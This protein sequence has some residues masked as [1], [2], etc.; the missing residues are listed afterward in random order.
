MLS[1]GNKRKDIF[2]DDRDRLTR[3][4]DQASKLHQV[5]TEY[6]IRCKPVRSTW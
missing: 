3:I 1:R 5:H 4:T 2:Y 6:G